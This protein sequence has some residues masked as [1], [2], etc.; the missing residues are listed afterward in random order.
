MRRFTVA[1]LVW[2]ALIFTAS[3]LYAADANPIT[4]LKGARIIDGTGNPPIEKGTVVIQGNRITAVGPADKV[5][6]PKGARV[7]DVTGRTIMPGMISAH[8]HLGVMLKGVQRADAYTRENVMASLNQFEQYGVTSIMSLGVNRDLIYDIREEQRAGK[9]SG[10]TVFPADRGFGVPNALPPFKLAP[11]QLYRPATPE[12]ARKMV[13][14]AAARHPAFLKVWVD[15]GFG[16]FPKMDPGVYKA[17]IDEGHKY[18]LKVAAHV[19]YL[20]DAKQLVA[21]GI[22]VLAHSIRDLP[23]DQELISS[24][25]AKGTWYIP[26]L[27]VDQSFFYFADNATWR[28]NQFLNA[29]L[30]PE[31]K[32][33]FNDPEY[34]AKTDANPIVAKCRAALAQALKNYKTLNDAGVKLGFGTDS[35]AAPPSR[36]P[37]W[38]EHNE[39]EL[40]VSTGMT[41]LRAITIATGDTAK[42]I[43]IKDRGTLKKGNRADLVV[44][45]ANPLDNIG[46]TKTL[47][48]IYHD[49]RE[50]APRASA[51]AV[52][53]SQPLPGTDALA[54]YSAALAVGPIEDVCD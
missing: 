47:V 45:A 16:Q 31:V 34:K 43:G 49:G 52:A 44:L 48:V 33:I 22:D 38:A 15:D 25:K 14:E 32:A 54:L 3:F 8:S 36:I 10:A 51:P 35:G 2:F 37:G 19:F 4:V 13:R 27:S 28:Q 20:V 12:E 11:D 21:D 17:V 53:K 30:S 1:L 29:G 18:K 7:V 50:V 23:V 24:M 26:T 5:K 39:L 40:M 6:T 46:N 9:L 42:L 41:P